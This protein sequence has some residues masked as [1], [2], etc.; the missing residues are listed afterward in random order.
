MADAASLLVGLR[1]FVFVVVF[2]VGITWA[3]V[4]LRYAQIAAC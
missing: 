3:T 2:A 1:P 4:R